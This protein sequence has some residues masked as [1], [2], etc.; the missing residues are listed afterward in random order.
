M[1]YIIRNNVK[2]AGGSGGNTNSV[3]LTMAEYLELE[4]NGHVVEDT[5]YYITDESVGN[6]I[7]AELVMFDDTETQMG[8]DNIQD[9]IEN[10]NTR[11]GELNSNIDEQNKNLGYGRIGL[12]WDDATGFLRMSVDN[13]PNIINLKGYVSIPFSFGIDGDGNYGYYGADG[14]LIPFKKLPNFGA[15]QSSLI[16]ITAKVKKGSYYLVVETSLYQ[17]SFINPNGN[18]TYDVISQSGSIKTDKVAAGFLA[19]TWLSVI[20]AKA[21]SINVDCGNPGNYY[22]RVTFIPL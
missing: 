2:Y 22:Y 11:V 9:A 3:D 13:A 4:K 10:V 5:T 1:A 16:S 20:K 6:Q 12:S 17:G 19:E 18:S 8:V 7:G 21:T 14:S 15:M